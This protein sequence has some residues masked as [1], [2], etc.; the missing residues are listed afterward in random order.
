LEWTVVSNPEGR[1]RWYLYDSDGNIATYKDVEKLHYVTDTSGWIDDPEFTVPAFASS[2]GWK[3]SL[4]IKGPFFGIIEKTIINYIF[5][6]GES[7]LIDH[8]M[9]PIYITYGGIPA[10]KWGEFSI[11][12]PGLFWLSSPIWFIGLLFI[13]LIIWKRSFKLGKKE[14]MNGLSEIKK[15]ITFRKKGGKKDV[16]KIKAK[17][18]TS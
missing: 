3:A 13:A 14:F 8:F 18:S 15:R 17:K 6:V 4:V 2:G 5:K 16:K 1:L 11:A 10:V 12:L 9:A 7:A